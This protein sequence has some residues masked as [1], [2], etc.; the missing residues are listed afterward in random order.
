MKNKDYTNEK[1]EKTKK[2][3]IKNE[4][5][6]IIGDSVL[7]GASAELKKINPNII[8]D[9]KVSRQVSQA[10]DI[11]KN[12]EREGKLGDI[13][14]IALGTNGTFSTSTGN[15]LIKAIGAK[16]QIYWVNVFG[17]HLHQ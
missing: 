10:K 2:Q 1:K 6:T 13:V 5:I 16:R 8:I 4:K 12:L 9:A 7:L 3:Q 17:E 14:V 15:E 11:V